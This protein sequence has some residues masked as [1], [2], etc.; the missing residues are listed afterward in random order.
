MENL[1]SIIDDLIDATN[2][3]K[4]KWVEDKNAFDPSRG[5]FVVNAGRY[6]I[7][8][9]GWQGD[10]DEG[11]VTLRLVDEKDNVIDSVNTKDNDYLK[12]KIWFL[13]KCARGNASDV[14]GA[15]QE[16]RA[17]LGI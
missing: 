1:E 4:I 6:V 5:D 12:D 2:S 14:S 3:G 8:I 10:V 11:G 7:N 17:A 16:V 9:Y 15:I 13:H